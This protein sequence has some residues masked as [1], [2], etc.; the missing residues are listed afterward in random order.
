MTK[1][2]L[3]SRARKS[4]SRARPLNVREKWIAVLEKFARTPAE[5]SDNDDDAAE[6]QPLERA[7]ERV[8][9]ERRRR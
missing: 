1:R 5:P 7:V 9:P 4:N 8:E 2:I 3:N 6:P